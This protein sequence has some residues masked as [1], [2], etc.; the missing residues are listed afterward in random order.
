MSNRS[1][2]PY[3]VP[4]DSNHVPL[5]AAASS[6]DG[7]TPVVLEADPSTHALLTSGGG[8]GGSATVVGIGPVGFNSSS[9]DSVVYTNT[10]TT[11]DTYQYYAGGTSG[12][13]RATV[14]ITYTDTTKS[15][16]STVVRS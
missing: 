3:G 7:I 6:A 16:V 1:G 11:V 2:S 10:S 9:Y 12:T 5:L 8:G 4:R 14:T 15:Q 13:L